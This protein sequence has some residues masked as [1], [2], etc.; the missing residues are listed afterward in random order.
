MAQ[1]KI[2][3]LTGGIEYRLTSNWP[4]VKK[5]MQMSYLAHS[6]N[7]LKEHSNKFQ[8]EHE[9]EPTNDE[10]FQLHHYFIDKK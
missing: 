4:E 5:T 2:A 8:H 7:N 3:K 9:T 1:N 10:E 6:D